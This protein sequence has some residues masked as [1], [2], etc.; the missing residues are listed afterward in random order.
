MSNKNNNNKGGGGLFKK[1]NKIRF[2]EMWQDIDKMT[3]KG[4]A[5][6]TVKA[7]RMILDSIGVRF[8][9]DMRVFWFSYAAGTA[10]ISYVILAT[11]TIIYYTYHHKFA[12]GIKGTCVVGIAIPVIGRKKLIK[13]N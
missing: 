7:C 2:T 1:V 5:L 4:K 6:L 11:Y 12:T 9:G 8:L 13:I 3:P 10:A